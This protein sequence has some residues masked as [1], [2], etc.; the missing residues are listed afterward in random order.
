M[1]IDQVQRIPPALELA[2]GDLRPLAEIE[3]A[4]NGL[5]P[6]NVRSAERVHDIVVDRVVLCSATRPRRIVDERQVPEPVAL[7]DEPQ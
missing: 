3:R 2:T 4:P 7:A 5:N 1:C 6:A